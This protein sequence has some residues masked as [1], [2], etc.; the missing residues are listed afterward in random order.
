[1]LL[2][3]ADEQ[4]T[5]SRKPALGGSGFVYRPPMRGAPSTRV[6]GGSRG[7]GDA[8]LTVSVIAPDHTGLT[9]Q[10]QPSLYWYTSRPVSGEVEVTI[11][12][13]NGIDPLLETRLAAPEGAGIHAIDLASLG[14]TLETDVEYSWFVA[15]VTDPAQRSNDVV[16]SGTIM[17]IDGGRD[18]A[19]R[20]ANSDPRQQARIY[21]EQGL[22]YDAVDSLSGLIDDN[23]RDAGLRADRDALLAQ[24]GLPTAAN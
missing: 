4:E 15:V 3:Q 22:W 10:S 19:A 12:D 13:A 16:A 2:A 8:P 21:A 18:V 6:G 17:R 7:L 14:V 23:P 24:V 11:I 1:L 5:A 20:L 9:T